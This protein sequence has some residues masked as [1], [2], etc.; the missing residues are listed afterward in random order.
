MKKER[1]RKLLVL[2][3][4][5]IYGTLYLI[6]E[7]I[8][9]GNASYFNTATT[10]DK[11]IPFVPFFVIF[12]VSWYTY[13]LLM[14]AYLFVKDGETY[15]RFFAFIIL[16]YT[17]TMVFDMCFPNGQNLRPDVSTLGN[18]Y[19]SFLLKKIYNADTP[20]NVLPSMHCLGTFAVMMAAIKTKGFK[21]SVWAKILIVI[22]GFLIVASTLLIKQHAFIDDLSSLMISLVLFYPIFIMKWKIFQKPEPVFRP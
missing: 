1:M 13:M 20:T 19:F 17:L 21:D 4:L 9:P 16:T 10:I 12:Y 7:F 11:A 2:L 22:W 18:D 14:M 8:L 5:P 15:Y 6:A 3:Y